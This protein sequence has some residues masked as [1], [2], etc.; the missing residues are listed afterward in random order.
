MAQNKEISSLLVGDGDLAILAYPGINF[1]FYRIF[2]QITSN[3]NKS[4]TIVKALLGNPF[5][6]AMLS[7]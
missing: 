2:L 3:E 6:F 4:G 5:A 7:A 1:M